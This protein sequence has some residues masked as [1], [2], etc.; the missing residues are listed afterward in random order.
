MLAALLC[1]KGC[2]ASWASRASGRRAIQ[3][4]ISVIW[5][6]ACR[7]GPASK[8]MK[9]KNL[10]GKRDVICRRWLRRLSFRLDETSIFLHDVGA[11]K[12]DARSTGF[13]EH[14][15][16]C[17]RRSMFTPVEEIDVGTSSQR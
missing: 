9:T 16:G 4:V 15:S 5:A 3:A 13:I 14:V 17:W 12:C 2:A 6:Q 1:R 7:V 10:R 11:R 8:L